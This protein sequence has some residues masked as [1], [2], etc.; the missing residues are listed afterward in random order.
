MSNESDFD[1]GKVQR[2]EH[3]DMY[4]HPSGV[5]GMLDEGKA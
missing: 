1:G 5:V 3:G 2:F 4:W